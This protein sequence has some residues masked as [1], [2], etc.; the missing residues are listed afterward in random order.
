MG[1]GQR[2]PKGSLGNES[3][4][5]KTDEEV[6]GDALAYSVLG[7]SGSRRRPRRSAAAP[8]VNLNY[9]PLRARGVEWASVS[10]D[11][12]GLLATR[13]DAPKQMKRS[14][15]TPSPTLF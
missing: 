8:R 12:R 6:A 10:A 1:I 15:A 13:V 3:G 7:T 2:G 4:R 5:A 14:P 9:H 11:L